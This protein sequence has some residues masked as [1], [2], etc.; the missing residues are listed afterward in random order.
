MN[1]RDTDGAVQV[2]HVHTPGGYMYGPPSK[3]YPKLPTCLFI[4][5]YVHIVI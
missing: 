4:E 2:Y 3:M 5:D 1:N